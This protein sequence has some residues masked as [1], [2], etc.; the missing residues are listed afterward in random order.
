M[1]HKNVFFCFE[2]VG[3]TNNHTS[4]N[5]NV[6]AFEQQKQTIAIPYEEQ[7]DI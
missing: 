7:P 3:V 1:N 4:E 5:A 2:C 6:V